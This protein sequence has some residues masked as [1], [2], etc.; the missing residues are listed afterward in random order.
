M[1]RKLKMVRF[2]T[3]NR[4]TYEIDLGEGVWRREPNAESPF[5]RRIRALGRGPATPTIADGLRNGLKPKVIL[6]RR[7][8]PKRI[9]WLETSNRPSALRHTNGKIGAVTPSGYLAR[10]I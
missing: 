1:N 4:S 2:R 8:Q 9:T 5:V 6:P 7:M 3:E 10:R